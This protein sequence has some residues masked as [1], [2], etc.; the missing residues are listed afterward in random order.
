MR[1]E[2]IREVKR[3]VEFF[4]GIFTFM[5]ESGEKKEWSWSFKKESRVYD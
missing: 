1:D 4:E 2:R 3:V 5:E